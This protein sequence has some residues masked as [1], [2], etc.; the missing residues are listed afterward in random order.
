MPRAQGAA[1]Q[2]VEPA[3]TLAVGR[4]LVPCTRAPAAS[5]WCA[6]TSSSTRTTRASSSDIFR[7]RPA[8]AAGHRLPVR[9][10]PPATAQPTPARPERIADAGQRAGRRRRA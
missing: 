7:R 9:A 8:A 6:T 1:P 3:C 10:G 5:R 2:P 4:D